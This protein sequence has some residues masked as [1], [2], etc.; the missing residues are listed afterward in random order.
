MAKN[1]SLNEAFRKHGAE[2]KRQ[3]LLAATDAGSLPGT[4]LSD[5]DGQ[6]SYKNGEQTAI[7]IVDAMEEYDRDSLTIAEAQALAKQILDITQ[8]AIYAEIERKH[9]ANGSISRMS[10]TAVILDVLAQHLDL[11]YH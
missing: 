9:L 7:A 6:L 3:S 5:D 1:D 10:V 8:G 11:A 2:K 4:E